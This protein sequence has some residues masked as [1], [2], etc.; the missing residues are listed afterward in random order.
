MWNCTLVSYT[1]NTDLISQIILSPG[2]SPNT[3]AASSGT[4]L[5]FAPF[6]RANFASLVIVV[7]RAHSLEF[8][9]RAL[10]LR[11]HSLLFVQCI[12]VIASSVVLVY[13]SSHSLSLTRNWVA[14]SVLQLQLAMFGSF[15]YR[16]IRI[17]AIFVFVYQLGY[18]IVNFRLAVFLMCCRSW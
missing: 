18:H 15:G 9:C 14:S 6:V 5:F 17:L 12:G 8:H 1:Q 10:L 7:C 11:S 13:F 4:Q 3:E 2:S 16:D